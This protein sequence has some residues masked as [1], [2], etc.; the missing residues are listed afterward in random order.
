MRILAFLC[1]FAS[2]PI[3]ACADVVHLANGD[4][5]SGALVSLDGSA[6]VI[7]TEWGGT[8]RVTREAV[9][10]IDTEEALGIE[11]EGGVNTEAMLV[12]AESGEQAIVDAAGEVEEIGLGALG[13]VYR[14]TPRIRIVDGFRLDATYGL[15]V[16]TGNA[17]TQTHSVRADMGFRRGKQR[18]RTRAELDRKI[19]EGDVTKDQYRLGHQLDLFFQADWYGYGSAEYFSDAIKEVDYRFTAG[20]G[21]GHQFWDD[22]LGALSAETGASLVVEEIGGDQVENP[23]LRL[24][25]TYNRFFLGKTL[26]LFHSDEAL[27]LTDFDRGQILNTSTGVRF[28][29][30]GRWKADARVDLIYETEPAPGNEKADVTYILGVGY[31]L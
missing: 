17:D 12:E 28:K 30:N 11:L 23:A 29:I 26:E 3:T 8:L 25:L 14:E 31:S 9:R 1:L 2:A 19:D 20:A 16:T 22:S 15:N 27:V 6:A 10:S 18:H 13:L 21:V 24:A 7:D 4:R 5:V